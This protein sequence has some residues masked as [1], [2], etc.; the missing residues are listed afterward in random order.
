MLHSYGR[1][2]HLNKRGEELVFIA[3][4][5]G[6]IYDRIIYGSVTDFMY[7]N[8]GFTKTGIFNAADASVFIGTLLIFLELIIF[9]RNS[10]KSIGVL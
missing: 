4:G 10:S 2:T 6:N 1:F 3:G 5:I 8:L 7:I 9:N